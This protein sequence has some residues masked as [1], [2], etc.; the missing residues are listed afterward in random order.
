MASEAVDGQIGSAGR[1][2]PVPDEADLFLDPDG[3]PDRTY[4]HHQTLTVDGRELEWYV[5]D[6]SVHASGPDGLA[7]AL[8]W[9]AGQWSRRHL[10]AAALRDPSSAAG[11]LAEADLD[12]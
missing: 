2:L 8:C 12:D 3:E 7:R 10:L 5:G 4:L 9:R 1:I 6:G 11:L